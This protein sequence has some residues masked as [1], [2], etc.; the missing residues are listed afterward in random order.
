MNNLID[1]LLTHDKNKRP[2][3]DQVI[4]F[5]KIWDKIGNL[6]ADKRYQEAFMENL[7]KKPT[8]LKK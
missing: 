5:P 7:E 6:L 1:S 3:I 2:N 8:I 4:Q